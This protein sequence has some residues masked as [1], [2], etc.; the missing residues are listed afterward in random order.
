MPKTPSSS[1]GSPSDSK[2]ARAGRKPSQSVAPPTGP[3]AGTKDD[4]TSSR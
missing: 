2:R 1:S 4:T 3:A